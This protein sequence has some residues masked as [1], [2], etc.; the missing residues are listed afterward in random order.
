M[1]ICTDQCYLGRTCVKSTP[2]P[3]PTFLLIG[4]NPGVREISEGRG[5]VGPAG[6]LLDRF[7]EAAGISRAE[8]YVANT[9]QCTDLTKSDRRPTP[10]E[11]EAC[12]PRLLEEIITAN[13]KVVICFGQT[14][15]A[16]F[17]PGFTIGKVRGMLRFKD[18]VYISTYHPA[19]A[20]G[21][22][23]PQNADLI[24]DDLKLAKTM[25]DYI[26]LTH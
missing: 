12:Y 7:L 11:I 22:R 13:P 6:K 8:C 14:A 4:E 23:S 5:F 20:M 1:D 15:I 19:S 26:S 16:K 25:A 2:V 10:A 9:I 24:I 21:H 3:N 18:R 17:F